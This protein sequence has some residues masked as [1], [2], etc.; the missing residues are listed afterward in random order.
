MSI[1]KYLIGAGGFLLLFFY[2]IGRKSYY[3]VEIEPTLSASIDEKMIHKSISML[4]EEIVPQQKIPF[5]L[6]IY[7]QNLEIIADFSRVSFEKH[8]DL[9]NGLEPKLSELMSKTYGQ[10]K[11]FTLSIASLKA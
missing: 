6:N 10:P 4:I 8:E 9:L 5:S 2:F 3:H 1:G 7:G 11:K